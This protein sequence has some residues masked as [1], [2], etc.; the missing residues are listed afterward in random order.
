MR[1]L[2]YTTP[3]SLA[4]LPVVTLPGDA[5]GLQLTGPLGSDAE[6][7]ALSAKFAEGSVK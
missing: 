3:I 1:I 2:R 4:G 6:L 5:G 7:L